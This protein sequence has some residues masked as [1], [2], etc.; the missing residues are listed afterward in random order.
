LEEKIM[1]RVVIEN[2]KGLVQKAGGGVAIE[3]QLELKNHSAVKLAA[4]SA[5]ALGAKIDSG[6]TVGGVITTT[7]ARQVSIGD[8]PITITGTHLAHGHVI[9]KATGVADDLDTPSKAH[10]IALFG[11]ASKITVGDTFE[12]T[13]HNSA[14][15]VTHTLKLSSGGGG[16]VESGQAVLIASNSADNSASVVGGSSSARFSARVTNVDGTCQYTRLA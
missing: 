6:T 13:I 1:V 14:T 16:S 5:G 15:D 12:F 7:G 2:K 9:S 3:P 4:G 10:M 8:A 11:G